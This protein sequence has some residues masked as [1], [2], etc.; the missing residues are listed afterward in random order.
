MVDTRTKSAG[1]PTFLIPVYEK[2]KAANAAFSFGAPGKTKVPLPNTSVS[3]SE[4][5]SL[6]GKAP[7]YP[8]PDRQSSSHRAPAGYQ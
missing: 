6:S 3:V 4:V 5:L 2:E 7:F 1:T 8:E